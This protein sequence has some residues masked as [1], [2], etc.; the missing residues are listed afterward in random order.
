MTIFII[1]KY[2]H[3]NTLAL[4]CTLTLQLL[5]LL[6]S[7]QQKNKAKQQPTNKNKTSNISS[8]M[9]FSHNVVLWCVLVCFHS[10]TP[11]NAVLV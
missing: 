6:F 5:V 1:G 9:I 7:F 3:L 8:R 4:S 2:H 11:T 10:M